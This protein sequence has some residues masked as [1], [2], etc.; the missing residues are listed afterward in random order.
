MINRLKELRDREV[1]YEY[2]GNL[3]ELFSTDK[4]SQEFK[5][6]LMA[7]VN[8]CVL[9][10]VKRHRHLSEY[11]DDIFSYCYEY[12]L[13]ICRRKTTDNFEIGEFDSNHKPCKALYRLIEFSL[14]QEIKKIFT[15]EVIPNAYT[16][17]YGLDASEEYDT[18]DCLYD[19]EYDDVRLTL[20]FELQKSR[21]IL[22]IN[23]LIARYDKDVKEYFLSLLDAY[24]DNTYVDSSSYVQF[25][26]K[27]FAGEFDAYNKIFKVY[28]N[29]TIMHCLKDD[30]L[31]EI[32]KLLERKPLD[33]DRADKLL[34]T[35][36]WLDKYPYVY[37]LYL[38]LGLERF[39]EFVSIFGGC[40]ISIPNLAEIR[41]ADEHVS[42][43]LQYYGVELTPEIK[44]KLREED[45]IDV[46]VLENANN[47]LK[48]KLT[49]YID[50]CLTI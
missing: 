19:F 31:M 5:E 11:Y 10:F 1:N 3:Y 34:L 17:N 44:K 25:K 48:K 33:S 35:L 40:K 49:Q 23:R 37:D 16:Q 13:N 24:I 2:I 42:I 41:R 6:Q 8:K 50:N 47:K 43:H 29:L 45:G 46:P 12:A 32:T 26:R 20:D 28:L 22:T 15:N 9:D 30:N 27:C 39:I 36:V 21:F 7:L 38:L 18:E 14:S 4:D